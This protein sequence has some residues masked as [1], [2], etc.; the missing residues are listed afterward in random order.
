M[1]LLLPVLLLALTGA[2]LAADSNS[3]HEK[4][5]D[6]PSVSQ[7][8]ADSPVP[9]TEPPYAAKLRSDAEAV[10]KGPDFHE[11]SSGTVPVARPWLKKWFKPD[12]KK[13]EKPPVLPNFPLL[14][15]ALKVI[16]IVVGALLL[17]W[18]L[19][20]GWQWL[21][22]QLA[23]QQALRR[24]GKVRDAQSLPLQ[25]EATLPDSISASAALAWQ[26]GQQVQALSL[27]YRGAVAALASRHQLSL[28][29]GATEGDYLRLLRRSGKRELA[30]GFTL[31]TQAWMSQAYAQR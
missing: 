28:P 11:M 8:V 21:S 2:S 31:I 12:T 24:H 14:A 7:P 22:P 18:L 5:A 19:W 16:V 30:S 26:A 29:D 25:D 1:K 17:G 27:L 20:R 13:K 23:G 15:Q 9:S 10:L 6:S 4:V 3:S